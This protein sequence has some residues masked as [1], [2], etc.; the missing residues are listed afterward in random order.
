MSEEL[1]PSTSLLRSLSRLAQ[2]QHETMDR[3]ALQEAANAADSNTANLPHECLNTVAKH[4]LVGAPRWLDAPDAAHVP[5]L[6]YAKA[7]EQQRQWGILRG[8]NSQNQWVSEWWDVSSQRWTEQANHNLEQYAIATLKLSRPFSVGNSPVYQ[9]IRQEIFSHKKR[10][11]DIMLGGFAINIVALATSFYS[12]QIYDRVVPT[13]STQTLLVLTLGV[14]AAV[15]FELVARRVRS[16]LNE[17]LIDEVDQRLARTVYM[18]FL[19]IRLDQLPQSVGGLAAQLRGYETVRG[20]FTSATSGFLIDAPFALLFIVVM[21][22]IAGELALIP[23]FFLIISLAIGRYFH[24][25]ITQYAKNS[26]QANNLKFGLLVETVEGAEIIKSGQGG[27]RMLRRW[28]KTT[29][30]ARESELHMRN[31]SEH[32]QHLAMS[33][34]QLSYVLVVATGALLIS[35]G[36]LTMG[37]LIA[38]SILSGRVLAPIATIPSQ[39]VQWAHAKAALQGLDQLWSLQDDHHGQEHPVIIENI[40]GNYRLESAT[41]HYGSNLALSV[42]ALTIR[43]GEKIGVVGSI[44]AGKTSLLRMLS[45]MYKPQAGRILLDDIDLAHVAKPALAERIGYIAQDGRLFSGTLRENLILGMIDPGDDVIIEA[46]RCTGLLE[47]VIVPN[48]KGLQQEIYEGGNGLSGG[49]RQLLNLTRA[50]IR[51]PRIWLMDE[52]TASMDRAFE[53][54]VMLALKQAFKPENTVILATHKVEMLDLVDRLIVIANHQI[55]LDGPKVQ[56]LQRLQIPHNQPIAQVQ[57]I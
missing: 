16:A 53:Q 20:F 30:T 6:L 15:M 57:A 50:F 47:A 25:Q 3:L 40:R 21:W 49:Q 19:S 55:V 45:G 36:T 56:I 17:R 34:Q 31:I 48:P 35:Q 33:F 7:G 13:G 2:L 1:L 10:L 28:M 32:S 24:K 37:G 46:S 14:V 54:Q 52:P 9:L 38:C 12:M 18:R 26:T 4:L 44:G 41:M 5:A 23:L 39:L 51:Q 42:P 8:R 22:L 27:W 29:D 43:A 11:F